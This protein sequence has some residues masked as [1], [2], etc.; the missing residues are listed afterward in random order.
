MSIVIC[1]LPPLTLKL[2]MAVLSVASIAQAQDHSPLLK[3]LGVVISFVFL[4]R[5]PADVDNVTIVE[6]VH[7][8]E[9]FAT[10]T[11]KT[12]VDVAHNVGPQRPSPFVPRRGGRDVN[13]AA[14]DRG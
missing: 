2:N 5:F 3:M 13:S 9:H 1:H 14:C 4:D 12:S 11:S 8:L 7:L 6:S 10:H